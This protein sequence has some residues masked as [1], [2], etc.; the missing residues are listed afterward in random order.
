HGRG[1]GRKLTAAL[2]RAS[3]ALG[4][5]RWQAVHLSDNHAVR[6][7]LDGVGRKLSEHPFGSGAMEVI[8][9]LH[10]PARAA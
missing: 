3:L 9:E 5:R 7:L 4:I 6:H 10:D 1:L 8:Y 2:A